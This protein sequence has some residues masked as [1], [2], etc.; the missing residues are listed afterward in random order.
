L[1]NYK[2]AFFYIYIMKCAILLLLFV[3]LAVSCERKTD[4]TSE[5]QARYNHEDFNSFWAHFKTDSLFQVNR[6]KFPVPQWSYRYTIGD[7]IPEGYTDAAEILDSFTRAEYSFMEFNDDPNQEYNEY[8]LAKSYY[9]DSAT[10]TLHGIENGLLVHYH[11]KL[12]NKNWYMV[13][14]TDL[15]T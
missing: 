2:A 12:I 3:L 4:I 14:I 15:S 13:K 11:F 6:I 1:Y 9:G 10:V 5:E 7:E 8:T